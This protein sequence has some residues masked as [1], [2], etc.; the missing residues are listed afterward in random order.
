MN[1]S[2]V[3]EGLGDVWV[4]ILLQIQWTMFHTFTF[5]LGLLVSSEKN[6]LNCLKAKF[7]NRR[8]LLALYKLS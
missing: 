7:D 4:G 8:I 3:K 2:A 6:I 1:E 5:P